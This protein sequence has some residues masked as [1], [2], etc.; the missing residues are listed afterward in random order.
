MPLFRSEILISGMSG[1]SIVGHEME[2]LIEGEKVKA[3][4]VESSRI[5][6]LI[7]ER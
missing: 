4:K 7:G 2:F 3:M 6:E 1:T 5:M